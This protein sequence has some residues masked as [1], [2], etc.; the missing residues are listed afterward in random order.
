[1]KREGRRV[2][3]GTGLGGERLREWETKEN[4]DRRRHRRRV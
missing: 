3:R 4:H 2:Q 1:M